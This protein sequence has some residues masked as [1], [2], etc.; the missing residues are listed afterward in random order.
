MSVSVDRAWWDRTLNLAFIGLALGLA[1]GLK[2]FYRRAGFEELLWVLAPTRQLVEWLSGARFELEAGLGYLSRDH[3]FQIVP[4]CAG[5]NFM[6]VAFASLACG[7]AHTC[8]TSRGRL[9]LL[10]FSALAAYAATVVA[11]AV[12]IS[13]AITLHA[14]TASWTRPGAEHL[15]TAVGVLIYS[16]FL[17]GL[18]ALGAKVTGARRDFAIC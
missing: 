12:R 14:A 8:S 18:F 5:V 11:N 16:L 13:T 6:I 10:L 17:G 7:L 1:W 4:A 15:H 2:D 3:R 9:A